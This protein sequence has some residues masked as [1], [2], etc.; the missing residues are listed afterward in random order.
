MQ[1]PLAPAKSKAMHRQLYIYASTSMMP[2]RCRTPYEPMNTGIPDGSEARYIQCLE[3]NRIVL[4][5]KRLKDDRRQWQD[6]DLMKDD[7]QQHRKIQIWVIFVCNACAFRR[8]HLSMSSQLLL[9][10]TICIDVQFYFCR[11]CALLYSQLTSHQIL[12]VHCY[13][14]SYFQVPKKQSD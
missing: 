8:N 1:R 12:Y 9:Y 2:C 14:L 5:Q 3:H 4:T 13:H 6:S 10:V 11:G 7:R